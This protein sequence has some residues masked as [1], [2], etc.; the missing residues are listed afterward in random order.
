[1]RF[2]A[3]AWTNLRSTPTLLSAPADRPCELTAVPPL[4]DSTVK[5]LLGQLQPMPSRYPPGM[6]PNL[7]NE[8]LAALRPLML[9]SGMRA[10]AEFSLV[11]AHLGRL[12]TAMLGANPA[13]GAA[14]FGSLRSATLQRDAMNSVA[15]EVLS[16]VD[17]DHLR[18]LQ[19]MVKRASDFRDQIAHRLWMMDEQLIDAVVLFDPGQVWRLSLRSDLCKGKEIKDEDAL[20]IQKGMVD[21]SQVWRKHDFEAARTASVH[22]A[23]A[24]LALT[25][26][27]TSPV[28]SSER[29]RHYGTFVNA[30]SL[31][32]A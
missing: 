27:I 11:E 25:Q 16:P 26:A 7:S 3:G 13:P 15:K 30:L 14:I 17:Q 20:A 10:I 21:A 28:D 4:F 9:L 18:S 6:I 1:M 24:T 5:P 31:S 23:V 22:A 19:K 2:D 8:H 32:I 29:D 12:M